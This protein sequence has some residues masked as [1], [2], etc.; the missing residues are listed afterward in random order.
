MEHPL[1][2]Y[3]KEQMDKIEYVP[4]QKLD[5]VTTRKFYSDYLT[6]SI[7]L[8]ITDGCEDWPAMTKWD[9]KEYLMDEFGG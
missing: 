7:P 5:Q 9:D 8:L 3:L 2:V 1:F 4:E 6:K